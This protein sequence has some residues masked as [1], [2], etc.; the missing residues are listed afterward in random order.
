M[1]TRRLFFALWPDE[2]GRSALLAAA[3]P[4]RAG[5]GA[6]GR[7]VPR[8]NLHLT[9]CFLGEIDA[10]AEAQ[11]RERAGAIRHPPVR[12]TFDA[13][14]WWSGPRVQ[15]ASAS[16]DSTAPL[17]REICPH[18][19]SFRAHVTLARE[20]P[21]PLR[22]RVAIEPVT[23]HCERFVLVESRQGAPYSIVGEWPLYETR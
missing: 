16:P 19:K 7:A 12:V 3:Q 23:W 17:A 10:A 14:E 22:W 11:A 6:G 21:K 9:L 15:V 8:G 13:L 5:V 1:T 4:A 18:I 20:V 2:A